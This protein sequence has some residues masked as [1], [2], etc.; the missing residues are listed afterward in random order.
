[1]RS[2]KSLNIF[3]SIRRQTFYVIATLW[4][5]FGWKLLQTYGIN[6]LN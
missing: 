6:G 3:E 4:R 2:Q 1:M 5:K